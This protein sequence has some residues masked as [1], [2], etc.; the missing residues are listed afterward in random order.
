MNAQLPEK[1][2]GVTGKADV[3]A[4]GLM[5]PNAG[6]VPYLTF[7]ASGTSYAM[8]IVSTK[9]IIEYRPVTPLAAMPEF[10]RGVIHLGGA[11]VPVVD[12]SARLGL[13]SS[14]PGKRACIVIVEIQHEDAVFD[15]GVVVHGVSD[16]LELNGADLLPPPRFGDNIQSDFIQKLSRIQGHC[17]IVMHVEQVLYP[18]EVSDLAEISQARAVWFAH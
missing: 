15:V 13:S 9:E 4:R 2:R 14:K 7:K 1:V 5:A 10:M 18:E 8:S 11:T 17:A 6:G 12:L 16:V 3:T